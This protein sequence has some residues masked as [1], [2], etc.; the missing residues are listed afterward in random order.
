MNEGGTPE[1][2]KKWKKGESGNPAG[3]PKNIEN[4]IKEHFLEEHNLKL[5]KSQAQDII[6]TI[7]GKTRDELIDLAKDDQLPFWIA[8]IANKA[9]RDFKKGS[10][11]ILDVLFDRVYGKP[12]EEVEQT[13]NGG[14][15]ETIEIVIHPKQDED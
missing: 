3:R 2:L 15:P 11:H 8:L 7:L 5:S 4:V 12:K 10:I 9:Q 1:N 6:K 14:K 13:V